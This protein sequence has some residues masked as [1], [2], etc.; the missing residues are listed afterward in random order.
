MGA[1]EKKYSTEIENLQE[2]VIR[3]KDELQQMTKLNIEAEGA[4]KQAMMKLD[5]LENNR[6]AANKKIPELLNTMKKLWNGLQTPKEEQLDILINLLEKTD[7]SAT[8]QSQYDHY[9]SKLALQLQL[10]QLSTRK[11]F[12][13]YRIKSLT[14]VLIQSKTVGDPKG[15]D[16]EISDL[17]AELETVL[18][19]FDK[20]SNIYKTAYNENFV[21]TLETTS[22]LTAKMKNVSSPQSQ[23]IATAHGRTSSNI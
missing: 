2:E 1:L 12:L 17:K 19:D 14:R 18:R 9:Q 4:T 22:Q 21:Q 5:K 15:V 16:D 11:D 7:Y 8:F 13:T 10:T 6:H 3:T 20:F 23:N